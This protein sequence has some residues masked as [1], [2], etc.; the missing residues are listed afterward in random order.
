MSA[1]N[2][3]PTAYPHAWLQP[4][5]YD[6]DGYREFARAL[7]GNLAD[8]EAAHSTRRPLVTSRTAMFGISRGGLAESE[9][10][11]PPEESSH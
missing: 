8:L 9:P 4:V 1:T 6:L 2:P 5:R 3:D 7:D 11:T 10:Q